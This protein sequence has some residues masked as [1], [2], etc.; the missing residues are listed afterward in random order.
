MHRNGGPP[1]PEYA[2]TYDLGKNIVARVS[3]TMGDESVTFSGAFVNPDKQSI[4]T[5]K[6]D[7]GIRYY[8]TPNARVDATIGVG[9]RWNTTWE[10]DLTYFSV[11]GEFQP[12]SAPVSVTVGYTR[13][14]ELNEAASPTFEQDTLSI[15]LRWSFGGETIR[16]RDNSTP[17]DTRSGNH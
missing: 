17:F 4:D 1:S 13:A 10:S 15:G 9:R 11:K 5:W 16:D 8:I 2:G 6:V 12:W 14:E 3:A 7:A